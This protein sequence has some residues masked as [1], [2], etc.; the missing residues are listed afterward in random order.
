LSIGSPATETAMTRRW[1]GD[2]IE[3]I[4][5]PL[6]VDGA[7]FGYAAAISPRPRFPGDERPRKVVAWRSTLSEALAD[8]R[9]ELAERPGSRAFVNARDVPAALLLPVLSRGEW[10]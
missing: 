1:S 6:P 10:V 5:R 8:V 4:A 2:R 9:R 3:L 7:I